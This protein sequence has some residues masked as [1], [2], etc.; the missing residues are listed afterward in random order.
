LRGLVGSEVRLNTLLESSPLPPEPDTAR[1][2]RFVMNT[3]EAAW[4]GHPE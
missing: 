1:V 2:E 3:Y 4:A